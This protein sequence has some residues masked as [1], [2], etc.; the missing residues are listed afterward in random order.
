MRHV[1]RV[2]EGIALFLPPRIS[3]SEPGLLIPPIS[4]P[5]LPFPLRL[6]PR[7]SV[8]RLEPRSLTAIFDSSLRAIETKRIERDPGARPR[9]GCGNSQQFCND[10]VHASFLC[11]SQTTI[12]E[13][14]TTAE[15]S[16]ATGKN[17][18][19]ERRGRVGSPNL[20]LLFRSPARN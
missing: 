3:S 5:L 9:A 20:K 19:G 4:S 15:R 1:T 18:A 6:R 2:P 17:E 13:E 11:G 7:S 10:A 12:Y 16:F 8:S 14:E